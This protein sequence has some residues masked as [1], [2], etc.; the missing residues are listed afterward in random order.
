MATW[1]LAAWKGL[2]AWVVC[3]MPAE[4]LA[5]AHTQV[6]A[7]YQRMQA[8]KVL[9]QHKHHDDGGTKSAAAH[10]ELLRSDL[11]AFEVMVIN[12]QEAASAML[13]VYIL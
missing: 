7:A 12:H 2:I 1:E 11:S 5:T 8:L 6:L 9:Q 3:Y 4:L 13:G 10:G